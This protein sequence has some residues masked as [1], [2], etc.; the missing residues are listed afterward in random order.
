MPLAEHASHVQRLVDAGYKPV[1][2]DVRKQ[3]VAD[4]FR[5]STGHDG[6][7][8]HLLAI[9]SDNVE[10]LVRHGNAYLQSFG[11]RSEKAYTVQA[12]EPVA[13]AQSEQS[14]LA[15]LK[16]VVLSLQKEMTLMRKSQGA[17]GR[18]EAPVAKS[19]KGQ[20]SQKQDK[21]KKPLRCFGCGE[22]GHIRRHCP[23][24]QG[25]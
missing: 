1:P 23:K 20:N 24:G 5:R 10:D 16:E 4:H 6:L 18:R 19:N 21:D 17:S 14:E 9:A 3:L 22:L 25:N 8:R 7:Y 13:A 2:S 15:A 11:G 12:V